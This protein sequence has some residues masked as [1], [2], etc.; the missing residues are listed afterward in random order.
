[1]KKHRIKIDDTG[2]D[3]HMKYYM[4]MFNISD[5]SFY[6]S[7]FYGFPLSNIS[8][9]RLLSENFEHLPECR[10]KVENRI[11]N[12]IVWHSGRQ[13]LE[14]IFYGSKFKKI[15]NPHIYIYQNKQLTSDLCFD[16]NTSLI[17]HWLED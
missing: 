11:D 4:S 15:I 3:Y 1:M 6:T 13:N 10:G 2:D 8:I 14:T 9:D 12:I 7:S 17:P 5:K 16:S